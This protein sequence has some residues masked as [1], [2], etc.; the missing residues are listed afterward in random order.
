MNV[1][2]L[3]AENEQ[4]KV[5]LLAIRQAR[6]RKKRPSTFVIRV[7]DGVV[8]FMEAQPYGHDS[9]HVDDWNGYR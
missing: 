1:S 9:R 7:V 2:R 3:V 6:M 8:Q 4:E 5:I